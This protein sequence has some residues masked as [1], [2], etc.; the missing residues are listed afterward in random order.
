MKEEPPKKKY[1]KD[2]L[3]LLCLLLCVLNILG[4]VLLKQWGSMLSVPLATS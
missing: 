3:V 1:S 2:Q 4:D